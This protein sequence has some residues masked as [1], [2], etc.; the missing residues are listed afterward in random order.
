[1]NR[2][3]VC[4][5]FL[6]PALATLALPAAAANPRI[7]L[8][9]ENA[10]CAEAAAALGKAAGIPVELYRPPQQEGAPAPKPNPVLDEKA[11]FDWT[12]IRFAQALRQLCERYHLQ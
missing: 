6:L 4:W 9:V 7:S 10:T 2:K 11:S 1:M 8:K 3:A 12:N 5:W